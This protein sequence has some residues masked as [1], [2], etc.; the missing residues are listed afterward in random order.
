MSGLFDHVRAEVEKRRQGQGIRPAD[1]LTL[2]PAQR[3]VMKL[4]LREI[5]L[6]YPE[7]KTAVSTL[8]TN[9]RLTQSE[10]DTTLAELAE[11]GWLIRMGQADLVSYRA[12][13]RRKPG[14][15]ISQSMW[16]KLE[17]RITEQR[18]NRT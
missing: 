10:L 17:G 1:L 11:A 15:K 2:P 6:S 14:S 5:Q 12:N 9:Q 18:E 3:R 7:L 4:L 16:G 13:L 8:P